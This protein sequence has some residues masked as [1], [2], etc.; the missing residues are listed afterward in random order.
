VAALGYIADST[1]KSVARRSCPPDGDP[2][3]LKLS[4]V[5]Q[6]MASKIALPQCW[7]FMGA[8]WK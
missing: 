8:A 7:F 5:R 6:I 1:E 4:G 3:Q 2:V